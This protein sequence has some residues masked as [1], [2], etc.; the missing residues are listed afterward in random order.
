MGIF[1]PTPGKPYGACK[2]CRQTLQ[3]R[4]A[5]DEHLYGNLGHRIRIMNPTRQQRIERGLETEVI[6]AIAQ[7]TPPIEKLIQ[8][9]QCT[10]QEAV[11]ALEEHPEFQEA[12]SN[13]E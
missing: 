11:D 6:I 7:F 4:E 5:A 13:G 1:D 2:T 10:R 12:V 9:G 3:T 8:A